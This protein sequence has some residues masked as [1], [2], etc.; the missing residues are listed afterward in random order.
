MWPV[1]AGA[2]VT[3]VTFPAC[4]LTADSD[5]RLQP[6]L[7]RGKW[8][9]ELG[10]LPTAPAATPAVIQPPRPLEAAAARLPVRAYVAGSRGR[11]SYCGHVSSLFP[12]ARDAATRAGL[13]GAAYYE[14]KTTGFRASREVAPRHPLERMRTPYRD[15]G[16]PAFVCALVRLVR[17][18][19]R[20]VVVQGG[21]GIGERRRRVEPQPSGAVV[22][23]KPGA[24][25]RP[26]ESQGSG[27]RTSPAIWSRTNSVC[28]GSRRT[29]PA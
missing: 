16:L 29:A 4:F 26:V 2:R 3:A 1:R 5:P 22:G 7:P 20:E 25:G 6:S 14:S 18:R 28:V 10:K 27:P 24:A 13:P 11:A 21:G 15:D 12:H 8:L 17:A 19:A 23:W 9:R